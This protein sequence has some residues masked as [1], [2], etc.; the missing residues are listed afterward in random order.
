[1]KLE[2]KPRVTNWI[3]HKKDA[4]KTNEKSR[5]QLKRNWNRFVSPVA[6]FVQLWLEI[7]LFQLLVGDHSIR[8]INVCVF[9]EARARIQMEKMYVQ[10]DDIEENSLSRCLD[11]KE[12]KRFECV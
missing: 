8:Q 7:R 5:V 4:H 12:Y 10:K 9:L 1:M 11:D 3:N 2:L 6:E